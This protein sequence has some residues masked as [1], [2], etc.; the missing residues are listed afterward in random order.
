[1]KNLK[2]PVIVEALKDQRLENEK[3]K[4]NLDIIYEKSI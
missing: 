1:M 4:G 3:N 2:I